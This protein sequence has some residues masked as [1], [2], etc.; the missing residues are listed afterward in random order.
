MQAALETN[1]HYNPYHQNIRGRRRVAVNDAPSLDYSKI[2]N[3][4]QHKQP[5]Q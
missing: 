4:L 1:F 3:M 5:I 2:K